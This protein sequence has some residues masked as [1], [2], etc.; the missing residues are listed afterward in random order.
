MAA[1]S[2]KAESPAE[3]RSRLLNRVPEMRQLAHCDV[4]VHDHRDSCQFGP[5][6]WVRLASRVKKL[7][8]AKRADGVVVLHGTD[9]LAYTAAALSFLLS[10]FSTPVIMTGSMRPL[11]ALRTDARRNLIASL[12]IAAEAK[13]RRMSGVYVFFNDTL[14]LGRTVRKRSAHEFDAF[15]SIKARPLA[16]VGTEVTYV[17]DPPKRRPRLPRLAFEFSDSVLMLHLTP[18]FAVD[19]FKEVLTSI[20]ALVLVVY[21]SVTGPTENPMFVRFLAEAK[22]LRVPVIAVT[23]AQ[24]TP[25]E[26][27]SN[28][29]A[30][31]QATRE[32]KK[33]GV[34]ISET[35]T[36]E[37]AYVLASWIYGQAGMNHQKFVRIWRQFDQNS[38]F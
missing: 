20:H 5:A 24:W 13:K 1:K 34:I 26:G 14:F 27:G 3:L 23:D 19:A 6:D 16:V 22:R 11:A 37:C 29:I 31:Y 25:G 4:V 8:R 32:L 18:G 12:E 15:E 9:T 33:S 38:D 35:I 28:K 30:S 21:P 7:A 36:P 2:G 17:E 10:D